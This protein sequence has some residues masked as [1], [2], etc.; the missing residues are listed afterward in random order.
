MIDVLL[1]SAI[2]FGL[3]I[4]SCIL[5]GLTFTFLLGFY[6][7]KLDKKN[8]TYCINCKYCSVNEWG[9]YLCAKK[10]QV[11]YI[12]GRTIDDICIRNSPKCFKYKSK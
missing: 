1:D 3:I 9:T 10:T 5:S 7:D 12:T 8:P 11:D 2:L 6:I 4:M